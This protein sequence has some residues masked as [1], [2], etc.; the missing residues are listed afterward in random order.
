M[1]ALAV[2]DVSPSALYDW[3]AQEGITKLDVS[4]GTLRS[5]AGMADSRPE[6]PALRGVKNPLDFEP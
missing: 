5:L 6:L 1:H 4:V 2:R 3:L